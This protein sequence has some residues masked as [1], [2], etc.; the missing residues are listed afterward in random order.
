[1][2]TRAG[3]EVLALEAGPRYAATE[4]T[5]DEVRNDVQRG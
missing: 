3:A 2:L 4:M 5:H 1:V